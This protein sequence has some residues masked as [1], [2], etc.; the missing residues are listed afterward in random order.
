MNSRTIKDIFNYDVLVIYPLNLKVIVTYS[1][2]ET[3]TVERELLTIGNVDTS[4]IG[5][6]S[7]PIAYDGFT[8]NYPVKVYGPPPLKSTKARLPR[9]S[10]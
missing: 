2:G 3:K 10:S 9:N 1:S 8:Y 5:D 6:A 4:K 7:L